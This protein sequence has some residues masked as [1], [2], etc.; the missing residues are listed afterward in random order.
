VRIAA[1]TLVGLANATAILL[2]VGPPIESA[3]LVPGDSWL[4]L[5]GE[6]LTGPFDVLVQGERIW[7]NGRDVY[8]PQPAA[9][10]VT[11]V[12][13]EV[14][15][16][17]EILDTCRRT[18]IGLA[19]DEGAEFARRWAEA[20]LTAHAEV[21][22]ASVGEEGAEIEVLWRSDPRRSVT[23][24]R[25]RGASE[26]YTSKRTPK[27]RAAYLREQLAVPGRLVFLT[28]ELYRQFD[29]P[30]GARTLAAL[31][32]IWRTAPADRDWFRQLRDHDIRL[33]STEIELLAER[34]SLP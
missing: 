25:W 30:D 19:Q 11:R 14:R 4:V 20:F 34:F 21:E 2:S 32:R 31:E 24:V 6:F 28:E 15:A 9:R 17:S 29:S 16:R 3:L 5:N 33:S 10:P 7:I 18:F 1:F 12:P 23:P 22:S 27:D 8:P 26:Y 13:A